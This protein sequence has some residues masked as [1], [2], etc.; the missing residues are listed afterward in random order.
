MM[1]KAGLPPLHIS[2]FFIFSYFFFGGWVTG[3]LGSLKISPCEDRR[4]KDT[5]N[6]KCEDRR[7]QN[8]LVLK[9]EELATKPSKPEIWRFEFLTGKVW[10]LSV[11]NWKEG[12]PTFSSN[13]WLD[14]IKFHSICWSDIYLERANNI[15]YYVH[16]MVQFWGPLIFSIF[17]HKRAIVTV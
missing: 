1:C 17:S 2:Q 16:P 12:S 5:Q 9:T 10:L 8:C 4:L 3:F 13:T 14:N 7:F 11:I 6:L 15:I